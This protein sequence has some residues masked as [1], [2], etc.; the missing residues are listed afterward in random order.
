MKAFITEKTVSLA[1]VGKFTVVFTQDMNKK[2]I[3]DILRKKYSID[4]TKVNIINQKP[5]KKLKRGKVSVAKAFTKAI[6]TV[7]EGQ[8]TPGFEIIE[9][10]KKSKKGL[11]ADKS[12]KET[13][14][15]K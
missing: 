14:K 13:V 5:V 9:E 1:K 4:A 7:K 15:T 8:K 10:E 11:K 3:I 6:I 2:E 12:T